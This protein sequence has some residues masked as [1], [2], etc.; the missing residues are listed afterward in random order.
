MS[1]LFPTLLPA[2]PIVLPLALLLSAMLSASSHATTAPGGSPY[3]AK[4][5]H[6]LQAALK[7]QGSDYQP[8]TEHLL[9]NGQPEYT[10]RLIEQHSPYLLQHAH[11]PVDWHP[12]G[13]DAFALAKQQNKPVFL[14]IGYSTC[15]WCHVMEKE[16]FEDIEVARYINQH[17]IAIKVD[18]ERRPD[19]D[20]VYMTAVMLF[21]GNGGW[22]MSSFLTPE[23]QPFYGGAYYPREHFLTLL[24]AVHSNWRDNEAQLRADGENIAT[25]VKQR[26]DTHGLA[27]S[28]EANTSTRARNTILTGRDELQGGFGAAPKFP[29]EPQLLL[30]LELAA[31][32]HDLD[33]LETATDALRAMAQGGIHDQVG[34]GFHRYAT[35][36][37]WLVPHFEEML[38]NQALLARAYLAARSTPPPMPTA[39]TRK[40]NSSCGPRPRSAT[41]WNPAM[42]P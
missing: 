5:Q 13:P 9:P 27:N 20:E 26:L 34:G 36:P 15:H 41:H 32:N 24:Q 25:R 30:L 1:R 40:A 39:R 42:P 38:Y 17:F 4:L 7:A 6:Q 22:P 3:P 23:G 31:R 29:H 21:T 2:L 37:D 35:T 33:A 10:N 12:W 18:R 14:S 16:S 11:N 8:R 19:V 28:L